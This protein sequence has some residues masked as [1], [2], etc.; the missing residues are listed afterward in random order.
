MRIPGQASHAVNAE[1]WSIATLRSIVHP[2]VR[3]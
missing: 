2:P 1:D 3:R